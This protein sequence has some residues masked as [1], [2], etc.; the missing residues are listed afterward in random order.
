MFALQNF[1]KIV[2]QKRNIRET[3]DLVLEAYKQYVPSTL[4]FTHNYEII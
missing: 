2:S 1:R 4:T 3:K